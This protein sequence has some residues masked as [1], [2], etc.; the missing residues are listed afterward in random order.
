MEQERLGES[1]YFKNGCNV[2]STVMVVDMGY[3]PR[4]TWT[5]FKGEKPLQPAVFYFQALGLRQA[6]IIRAEP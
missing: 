4:K 5:L 1:T 6:Q 3:Y 2:F